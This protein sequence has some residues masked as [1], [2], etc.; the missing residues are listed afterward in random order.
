MQVP[1]YVVSIMS[2]YGG[3]DIHI[4]S[5]FPTYRTMQL[6]MYPM[7]RVLPL[8]PWHPRVFYAESILSESFHALVSKMAIVYQYLVY[9]LR[10]FC[11]WLSYRTSLSALYRI[12]LRCRHYIVSNFDIG[13]IW[14]RTSISV[15]YRI[16]LVLPLVPWH[17]RA[18]KY[19]TKNKFD[20]PLSRNIRI[21]WVKF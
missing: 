6:S 16:E 11:V 3:F 20:V 19:W 4:V 18:S 8:V 13:I 5:I 17:P 1:I 15:L 10:S 12:E 7:E 14:Y 9:R 21:V 2:K